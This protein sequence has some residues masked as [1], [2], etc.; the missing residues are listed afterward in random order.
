MTTWQRLKQ[1]VDEW[2]SH[3]SQRPFVGSV[4]AK[5]GDKAIAAGTAFV[6]E[7]SYFSV[8]LVEMGLAEGGR[9]FA[10]FL[11]LGV[12]LTEYTIGDER[13]RR[14]MV[15]SNDLIASQLKDSGGKPGYIEFTNMYAVRCAPMKSDNL[16]LFV[17]MFRMP[18]DD[19][20]KQVLQIAS[21][22][23]QQVGG[24][25]NPATAAVTAG[26]R[27]AEKVYD[28]VSGLFGLKGITPLF[29]FADGNALVDSRYLLVCGPSANAIDAKQL[30][31]LDNRLHLD[32]KRATGFD[33]CLVAI[34]H[35]ASRLPQGAGTINPLTG[36]AFHRR[37]REA[38][39]LLAARNVAEAEAR[40]AQLRA[41][42]VVSPE[43]TEDD[44]LI[45]VAAYDTGF[46]KLR[47][48]LMPAGSGPA[49]RGDDRGASPASLLSTEADHRTKAGQQITGNVLSHM[50]TRLLLASDATASKD[51]IQMA[52]AMFATEAAALRKGV[53]Q[54]DHRGKGNVAAAVAEAISGAV[55]H[56]G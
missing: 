49:S 28:G 56:R 23:T 34:E 8:R 6:P 21:D 53:G 44:R 9:F 2:V 37:Y 22:L 30:L 16:S 33:Y 32:G 5:P 54:I 14:P 25:G 24:D 51:P 1:A 43:L 35:T 12:C 20:A 4:Q 39:Q 45:A 42:V 55:G 48:A 41:E 38:S 18:Y 36:L 50:A 31:V 17:G 7:A 11:P 46:E 27:V 26:L 52:E 10:S 19:L 47:R 3:P 15:L 29:G 13:Q 40:I